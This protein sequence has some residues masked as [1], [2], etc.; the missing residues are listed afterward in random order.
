MGV[1]KG[2]RILAII[3]VTFL[4]GLYVTT[5][6]T[7]FFVTPQ[8]VQ[9]FQISILATIMIPMM[10]YVLQFLYR[11]IWKEDSEE[12]PEEWEKEE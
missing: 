9:M 8:A 3:L 11:L 7:A 2:K 4:L 5:I 10:M 12:S 1:K 6:I